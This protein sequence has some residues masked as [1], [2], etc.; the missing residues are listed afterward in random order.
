MSPLASI[1]GLGLSG[2]SREPL[3]TARDLAIEAVAAAVRDAGLAMADLDGL[4]IAKS[5]S[6]PLD[7]LPLHLKNDLG[8]GELGL[9]ANV[10][11]EG[12]STLQAVQYA[13]LAIRQGMARR[14]ACV[15]ADARVAPGGAGQGF[16]KSMD[17]SGLHDWDGRQGLFGPVGAYA[18]LASEQM[19]R[20]GWTE[21]DL[22]AYAIACRRWAQLNPAAQV[23]DALTPQGHRQSRHI[24]TPLRLLDCAFP[25]NG[26]AAVI[27]AARTTAAHG[28]HAPVHVL[29]MG[30]GHGDGIGPGAD[31]LS[32][33]RRASESALSM[34]GLSIADITQLQTYDPFSS[35]GLALIGGYGVCEPHRAGAFVRGGHTSPGGRLPVNTGGGHLSGF[36]LQGMTPLI[37]AV[38]QARGEAGVRQ[39][40][41]GPILVGG[42][43][44]CLE[45]HAA[46]VLAPGGAA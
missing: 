13:A 31:A 17:V 2:L 41:A 20:H 14:V 26:A 34:A 28:G 42:V 37:E 32:G 44:G 43:G 15:F 33:A 18:L 25:I 40:T 21:D 22:A 27:V 45:Y 10:E 19:A 36:Y 30:Q 4:L 9:L 5:P 39:C 46:L 1:I 29:G 23:R 16:T 7:T 6:A 12:T 24:A 38:T 35:V 11:G 3:G 8:M